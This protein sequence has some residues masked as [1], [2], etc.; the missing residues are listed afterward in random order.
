ME[1][2]FL[3]KNYRCFP[4][5]DP[6]R[7]RVGNGFIALL[8]QNNSGKTALLR[9]FY[10]FRNLFSQ[11]AQGGM[12]MAAFLGNVVQFGRVQTHD[13]ESIFTRA[14]DRPLAIEITSSDTSVGIELTVQRGNPNPMGNCTARPLIDGSPVPRVEIGTDANRIVV[15]G[16]YFDPASFVEAFRRI[17]RTTYIPAFRNVVNA[18]ATANY[19]DIA[20]GQAFVQQWREFQTGGSI[21][22]NELMFRVVRDIA[23]IFDFRE[24]Q[25]Q[26]SAD[27]TTLQL[28]VDGRSYR[29]EELGSGIAQFILTLGTVAISECA[30][31]LI[32][33]PEI[34]LHPT[35]QL[36]F[37]TTLASFAEDGVLFSTHSIGLA[38]ATA[39]SIYALIREGDGHSSVKPFDHLAKNLS[40]FLGE[41]NYSGFS[42]LG[43]NTILLVEGS[44]EVKTF[45][46]FLRWIK[47]DHEF[48]L[49]PLGGSQLINRSA[50]HQ[51]EEMKRI[52][53][54]IVAII[55][56][57]R[58]TAGEA[59]SPDREGF[60]QAC[61]KT[62]IPCHVLERRAIENYFNENAIKKV[63]G[64]KYRALGPYERLKDAD[65]AW[66]KSENWRIVREMK[67]EDLESTDLGKFVEGLREL[68]KSN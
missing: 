46:Q 1:I 3:I 56:S 13:M 22:R 38:R 25:I 9:F 32:D 52:T 28:I 34:G 54:N 45:Q 23:R 10:E 31:V 12:M 53:S 26:A 59:L 66:A 62:G 67:H 35:L 33:E 58:A 15:R 39:D 27:M 55:D 51:L 29:L 60:V 2:E 30:Y 64:D 5:E 49:F 65:P 61:Q 7:L 20:V 41:L 37:L 48:V 14:N 36:D 44:S 42:M 50:E 63:K 4:D 16:Q 11:L 57:E 68:G 18:G 24:L 19:F 47:R 21:K 43:F 40:E 17:S 6:A 8:G